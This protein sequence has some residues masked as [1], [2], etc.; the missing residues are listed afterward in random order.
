MDDLELYPTEDLIR[1]LTG[2]A[3]FQGVIVRCKGDHKT[4]EW[5]SRTFTVTFANLNKGE[6]ANLL[7][8]VSERMRSQDD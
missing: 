3:T 4:N 6:A 8:V 2:R 1:E 7:E 5:K